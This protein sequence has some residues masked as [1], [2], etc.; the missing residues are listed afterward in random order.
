MNEMLTKEKQEVE[1][2]ELLKQKRENAPSD[3]YW[4]GSFEPRF[5][6]RL[7][8]EVAR[9]Q[10]H[11]RRLIMAGWISPMVVCAVMALAL[12]VAYIFSPQRAISR[13]ESQTT[14]RDYVVDNLKTQS[15]ELT[16]EVD[17]AIDSLS[18]EDDVVASADN[19]WEFERASSSNG[20]Q[21]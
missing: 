18:F 11:R 12:T 4:K 5:T 2:D 9:P 13:W 1:V 8:G 19:S 17:H 10:R 3:S 14:Q 15:Q 16:Y 6:R 20:T 21:F 7:I